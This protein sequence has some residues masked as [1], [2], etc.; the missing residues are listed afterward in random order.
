MLIVIMT[1]GFKRPFCDLGTLKSEHS[2]AQKILHAAFNY[3]MNGP[4]FIQIVFV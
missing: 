4:D 3:S 2:N 1:C